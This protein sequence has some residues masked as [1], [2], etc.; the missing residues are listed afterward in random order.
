MLSRDDRDRRASRRD[1]NHVLSPGRASSGIPGVSTPRVSAPAFRSETRRPGT[2]TPDTLL[3]RRVT[4]RS[5]A[6]G[7]ARGPSMT[8]GGTMDDIRDR[9]NRRSPQLSRRD[10]LRI[11]GGRRRG[12]CALPPRRWRPGC[13]PGVSPRPIRAS[14]PPQSRA[15]LTPGT[16]TQIPTPPSPRRPGPAARSASR[17]SPTSGS[18]SAA[19]TSTGKSW[20]TGS[21]SPWT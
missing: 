7:Q 19:R 10:A 16:A 13:T 18:K 2:A 3:Y 15:C 21:A 4:T 1:A 8:I 6:T 17:T 14:S 11:G 20:R 9:E 12:G 5:G